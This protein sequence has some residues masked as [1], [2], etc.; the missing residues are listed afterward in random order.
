MIAGKIALAMGERPPTSPTGMASQ[1]DTDVVI[2]MTG[3]HKA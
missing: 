2:A 1:G 3:K